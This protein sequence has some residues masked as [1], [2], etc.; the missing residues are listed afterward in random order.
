MTTEVKEGFFKRT[1]HF[2]SE[3]KS[4]VQKVTWPTRDEL[5]GGTI[6]LL[7]VLFILCLLLGGVDAILGKIME[8]VMTLI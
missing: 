4:E 8:G 2:F 1:G 5:Y 6:V 7:V 3:V